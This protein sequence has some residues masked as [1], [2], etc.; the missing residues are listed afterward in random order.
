M[1]QSF[2]CRYGFPVWRVRRW[3]HR[4]V[5][6]WGCFPEP[7]HGFLPPVLRFFLGKEGEAS[8]SY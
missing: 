1:E 4:R 7:V 5:I 3:A 6:L 2:F 8:G